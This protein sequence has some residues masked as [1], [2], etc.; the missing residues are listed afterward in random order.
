MPPGGRASAHTSSSAWLRGVLLLA[1]LLQAPALRA[2]EPDWP[3]SDTQRER[4]AA[5]EVLVD[6]AFSGESS[7]GVIRA[8]VLVHALN[9]LVFRTMTDCSKALRYVPHLVGC[10]VLETT[11]DGRSQVIEHQ[12]DYSWFLP[13]TRYIFRADYEPGARV[14]FKA[15]SGDFSINEGLWELVPQPAA[16][17]TLVTYRVR[18]QPR[19]FAPRWLVRASLKRELPDLMRA[20]R[21]YCEADARQVGTLRPAGSAR[22]AP[23]SATPPSPPPGPSDA[24]DDGLRDAGSLR[25]SAPA[26]RERHPRQNLSARQLPAALDRAI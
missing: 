13:R 5:G 22:D 20:L 17:S 7:E 14:H 11:P 1:V 9:D 16:G 26:G 8:A 6:A 12:A 2:S 25:P 10:K 19:F 4:L 3:L 24:P 18:L 15:V 21:D 23:Q